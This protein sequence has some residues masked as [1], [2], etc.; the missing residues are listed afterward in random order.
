[1]HELSIAQSLVEIASEAARKAGVSDVKAVHLQLG[2]LS[3]V[4][5]ESLLFCYDIAIK[6]TLLEGSRLEIEEVPIVIYCPEC[7]TER[8]LPNGQ[9]FFCPVCEWPA[10]NVIQ[11]KELEITSLEVADDVEAG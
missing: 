1:M 7:A 11:G 3:G 9:R 4:V 6:D 10:F 5:K 8:T 2:A